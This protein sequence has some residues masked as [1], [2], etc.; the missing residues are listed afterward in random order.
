[1]MSRSRRTK[2]TLVKQMASGVEDGTLVCSTGK[3]SRLIGTLDGIGRDGHIE[4]RPMW[5]VRDEIARLAAKRGQI[6]VTRRKMCL[7]KQLFHNT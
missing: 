3:I 5:T 1:M 7:E 2:E 6:R 4:A